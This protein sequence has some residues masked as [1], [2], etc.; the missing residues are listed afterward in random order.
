MAA[1]GWT[2]EDWLEETEPSH[3]VN[4][5]LWRKK[6]SKRKSRLYAVG[7]C[8]Q[9]WHRFPEFPCRQV[10]EVAERYADRRA[11][12][13]QLANAHSS[14]NPSGKVTRGLLEPL[15]ELTSKKCDLWFFLR[16]L[17]RWAEQQ[18]FQNLG[19]ESPWRQN[20]NERL[21]CLIRDVVGN[22]YRP[23]AVRSSWLSPNVTTIAQAIYAA[24]RFEDM[25]VLAD[26]LEEAGCTD[27]AILDH[28]RE[29]GPHVRGCWLVDGILRK[30]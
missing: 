21:C 4:Q 6:M 12:P 13:K 23:V 7:C 14:L 3:L 9:V 28:C 19:V 11:S 22:P 27:A 25:P 26:A 17:Q 15:R 10:V 20:W 18:A 16:Q 30:K 8:R 24:R 29:Q 5:A 1:E 2:E